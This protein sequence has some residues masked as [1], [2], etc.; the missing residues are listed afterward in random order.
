VTE[1]ELGR[2][3]RTLAIGQL[4]PGVIHEINNPLFAILGILEF[5]LA[6]TQSGTKAYERL[7]LVQQSGLEIK[8]VIRALTDFAR[9]PQDD[10]FELALDDLAAEAIRLFR[11][12]SVSRDVELDLETGPGLLSVHGNP[13]MLKV[14]VLNVLTHASQ[15]MPQGGTVRI[16][17]ARAGAS[18][19]ASIA[20][21]GGGSSMEQPGDG[22]GLAIARALL[23]QQG[24]D[25]IRDPADLPAARFLLSLPAAAPA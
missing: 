24:G 7:Q 9:E 17:V 20:Y 10:R 8:D 1:E 23:Q 22:L 15:A 2:I 16:D 6:D 12:T 4:A 11:R 5:L 3:G 21:E 18:V 25:L 13:N 19:T 14:A